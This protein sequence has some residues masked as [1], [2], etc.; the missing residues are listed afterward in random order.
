MLDIGN[1]TV[2]LIHC[3]RNS[4]RLE[5]IYTRCCSS[6]F[7]FCFPLAYIY[8]YTI[9]LSHSAS[10]ALSFVFVRAMSPAVYMLPP[11]S[12]ARLP[13]R[14]GASSPLA[15]SFA[16]SP[17]RTP[18][19]RLPTSGSPSAPRK[20]AVSISWCVG[21]RPAGCWSLTTVFCFWGNFTKILN[22]F[23]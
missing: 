16:S 7:V 2:F 23:G 14:R 11:P 6:I 1:D 3:W 10:G 8:L 17:P 4:R 19:V 22:S 15:P 9:Q 20:I 21:S 18:P 5:S 12:T 13:F